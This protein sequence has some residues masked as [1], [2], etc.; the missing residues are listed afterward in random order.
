MEAE[1]KRSFILLGH[2]SCGKTTLSE[3]ILFASQAIS[4]K[5]ATEQGNTVS[6]YN[7]DEIEHK[8]SINMG[9]LFCEHQGKRIQFI[10]TPGYSDFI[11]EVIAGI[12]AVDGA[13]V[14]VDALSGIELG[15]ERSWGMLDKENL[16]RIVFVNKLD[17]EGLDEAK[18]I[19]ELKEGLSQNC[20]LIKNLNDKDLI[21]AVAESDDALLERYLEGQALAEEEIKPALHRAVMNAVIFPVIFG[22]AVTDKGVKELLDAAVD[23]LPSPLERAKISVTKADNQ[24]QKELVFAEDGAACGF[25]F[26]TLADP[27]MGQLTLIRL[28]SGKFLSGDNFYNVV[29]KAK[30]RVGTIYMLQ[31]KEHQAQEAASCGDIVAL[32]KLKDTHTSDSIGNDKDLYLFKPLIFPEPSISAS[33]KPKTRADEEK[34]SIALS[35]L[36]SEDK[37]LHVSRNEQTKEE[38]LSGIGNLHLE[39]SA[40]RLASRFHVGVELGKPKVPYKE[41]IKQHA[42]VQGRYKKQSGGRGQYGDVWIEIEPL[43]SGNG[44]FEFVNKIFGGA[45]P[46]NYI[47]AVEKGVKQACLEGALAGYPLTGIKV[48]LFD[49]SY[50]TVDSSD[51]AFQIAGAMALRKAVLEAKPVLLEPIMDVEIMVPEAFMGQINGDINSRRGR[52]MGMDSKG[53]LE[54][55]KAKIPLSEMFEYAND[56]KSMTGGRGSYAMKFGDYHEVPQKIATAVISQYKEQKQHEE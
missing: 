39:I 47:P 43:P 46:R 49:G 50:H 5:G 35:K 51:M 31:G 29:T 7:P 4:R 36:I 38:L 3:S 19:S 45:I 54:V 48:I 6:D 13:I 9:F 8:I 40:G 41:T 53:R 32:T 11:G 24:E 2:A 18:I 52:V 28:F 16:P 25:V 22:S 21:E 20:V 10:D 42:K 26:K 23:Y 56:L 55:I 34:I 14:V 44:D 15:T 30:E 37:T 27:H 17:K 12:R 33:M 1:N